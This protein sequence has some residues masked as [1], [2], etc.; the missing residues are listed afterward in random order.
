MSKE[1]AIEVSEPKGAL[2]ETANQVDVPVHSPPEEGEVLND[3]G[4]EE[5]ADGYGHGV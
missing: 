4:S 2:P 5:E 1:A 3:P